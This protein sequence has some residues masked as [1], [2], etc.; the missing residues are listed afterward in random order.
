MIQTLSK[1]ISEKNRTIEKYFYVTSCTCINMAC[2]YMYV[3]FS[4]FF[5]SYIFLLLFTYVSRDFMFRASKSCYKNQSIC[6]EKNSQVS[7]FNPMLIILLKYITLP[8]NVVKT[9]NS[10]CPCEYVSSSHIHIVV[11]TT[12][13]LFF[14]FHIFYI[15]Y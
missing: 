10:P 11:A 2:T 14:L 6:R 5:P 8:R 15:C 9:Q 4:F 1:P 12:F 3:P 13:Y 7:N